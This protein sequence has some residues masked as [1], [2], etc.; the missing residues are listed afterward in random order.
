MTAMVK[1]ESMIDGFIEKQIKKLS[2]PT[3]DEYLQARRE[4]WEAISKFEFLIG[5]V[6]RIHSNIAALLTHISAM[7]A[8]LG[9]ILIVFEGYFLTTLFI[10]TEMI[11]YT[12]LAITCVYCIRFHGD[13]PTSDSSKPKKFSF[14]IYYVYLRARYIYNICSRGVLVNTILFLLTIFVHA[15]TLFQ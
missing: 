14:G 7:I 12:F 8:A 4:Y 11:I 1:F 2:P 6:E 10:F 3:E 15:L 9:I 5:A 13:M